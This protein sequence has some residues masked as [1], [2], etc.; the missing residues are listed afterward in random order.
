MEISIEDVDME[1]S[2]FMYCV[3]GVVPEFMLHTAFRREKHYTTSR[4]KIIKCPHCRRTFT[5]VNEDERIELY[6]HSKK[7]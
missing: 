3:Y 5:T 2:L 4:K 6:C 1:K 7:A